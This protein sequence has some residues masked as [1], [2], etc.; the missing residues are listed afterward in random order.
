[1]ITATMNLWLMTTEEQFTVIFYFCYVITN[2]LFHIRLGQHYKLLVPEL[3]EVDLIFTALHGM[4]T[5][6]SDEISVCPSVCLSNACI[7]TKRKKN[8]S[9]FFLPCERTFSLVL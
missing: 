4:Q 7:V 3:M 2:S 5:R 1:M 9:R 8:L 6:S